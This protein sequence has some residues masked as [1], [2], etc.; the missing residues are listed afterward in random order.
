M[1]YDKN[2]LLGDIHAHGIN[3]QNREI[4]LHGYY[5]KS[6]EAEELGVEYRMATTFVKNINLLQS[7]N[8]KNILI[9]MHTIGGEWNDGMAIYNAVEHCPCVVNI[10]VYAHAR[11]MSSIILQAADYR[12]MT[13]D[14]DFM[15][16]YGEF[17][18]SGYTL[19]SISAADYEKKLC[20]RM[21]D[22]YADRCIKGKF[23]KEKYKHATKDKVKN[24]L[25]RK[26]QQKGDWWLG[27]EESVYYGFADG[28][29][30]QKE[31]ETIAQI[32]DDA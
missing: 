26:M 11:S 18:T 16:H 12:I 24:F 8:N 22:I 20:D 23:F 17:V 14:A 32:R 4:Y 30:G 5:D 6:E 28:I 13:P 19:S 7:I 2:S 9:Y 31:Y 10:V 15:I 21:L 25:K 27:A 3:I 29:L 1:I